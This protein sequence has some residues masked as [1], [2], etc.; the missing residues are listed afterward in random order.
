MPTEI[1]EYNEQKQN[2]N[3]NESI[4]EI[5]SS[6]N[7]CVLNNH[8]RELV[9]AHEKR[10]TEKDQVIN[11]LEKQLEAHQIIEDRNTDITDKDFCDRDAFVDTFTLLRHK[12]QD[13]EELKQ[14]FIK[15]MNDIHDMLD[16]LEETIA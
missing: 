3:V 1:L 5:K 15:S 9:K 16:D 11:A 6:E 10:L 14:Q 13:L 7:V 12:V 2:D 8:W 4:I